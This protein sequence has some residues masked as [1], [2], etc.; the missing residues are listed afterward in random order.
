MG[1]ARSDEAWIIALALA[2]GVG[3]GTAL[4][5]FIRVTQGEV[6]RFLT[7]LGAGGAAEDLTQETYLRALRALPSFVDRSSVRTWL[8]SIARRVAADQIR[9]A[10]ARSCA[11]AVA[12]E[13]AVVAADWAHHRSGWEEGELLRELV[14]GLEADRRDAFVLTQVVGLDYAAAAE[15]CDCPVGTIRSRVA[16]ARE[17]LI[18]AMNNLG[19]PGRSTT[20]P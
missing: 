3:D 2:A 16:Q 12:G 11:E 18:Q 17:D 20:G 9:R 5:T 1:V 15:V 13:D 6:Y 19:W 8:L 14:A 10:N 4:T 7:Y